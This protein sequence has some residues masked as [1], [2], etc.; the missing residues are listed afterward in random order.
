MTSIIVLNLHNDFFQSNNHSKHQ[1][2]PYIEM[3]TRSV[4]FVN[5]PIFWV[6]S[7]KSDFI[8]EAKLLIDSKLD[9]IITGPDIHDQLQKLKIKELII[10]GGATN[11]SIIE[12]YNKYCSLGYN[13]TILEDCI[14]GNKS[15]IKTNINKNI[16]W[17]VVK[18]WGVQPVLK[19]LGEG[20][21]YVIYPLLE[22]LEDN[23]E[24]D[25]LTLQKEIKWNKM[26]HRGGEVPRL[27]AV[28]GDINKDYFPI[29]RHPVD[30]EISLTQW[31]P[32]VD[33]LRDYTQNIT[34]DKL[35]H[36]LIQYY[37]DSKD[38]ISEHS[39]KTLDILLNSNI[40]NLT[41]GATRQF[42]LKS[43]DK[44]FGKHI[45]QKIDLS[46]KSIFVLGWKTNQKWLHSITQDKRPLC[47][48][49]D[50]ELFCGGGRI[51]FT[52]RQIATFC[53]YDNKL[54]GQGAKQ[55]TVDTAENIIN[56]PDE[57]LKL[58]KIFSQENHLSDFNWGSYKD[59]FQ[60]MNFKSLNE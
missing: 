3:V 7:E 40:V 9:Y 58:L 47:E 54:F 44:Y 14:I 35:N 25:Y 19:N 36:C 20:D 39:D 57:E 6:T 30:Y 33:K 17:K 21:S 27:I 10:I 53:T 18:T 22:N 41:I 45:Y 50:D 15:P 26:F 38:Y 8:D 2:L 5:Y 28:Q 24:S 46:N 32:H 16:S 49:R 13:V 29:Y 1:I 42:I 48:K 37:R 59:G 11:K 52:F 43:K 56:D 60:V 4:R 51:S 12:E 31:T 34:K 55:K 23:Q